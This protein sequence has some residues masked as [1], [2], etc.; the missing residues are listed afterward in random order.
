MHKFSRLVIDD[1]SGTTPCLVWASRDEI[2]PSP[3]AIQLGDFIEVSGRLEWHDNV[4]LVIVESHSI[5]NDDPHAELEWWMD[6]ATT[7]KNAYSQKF[8]VSITPETEEA[9]TQSF[10]NSQGHPST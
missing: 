1:G 6:M 9:L 7:F 10:E 4:A 8:V 3:S 2:E 5:L